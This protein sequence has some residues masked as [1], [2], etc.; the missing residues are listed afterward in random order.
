[1]SPEQIYEQLLSRLRQL[2]RQDRLHN[3]L[4]AFGIFLILAAALGIVLPMLANFAAPS[5][6]MRW[7]LSGFGLLA[8][9]FLMWRFVLQ[10]PLSW[11]L[12][13]NFPSEIDLALRVGR[14]QPEVK[15]RFANALQVFHET[16][17]DS[18]NGAITRQL[19]VVALHEAYQTV[20]PIIFSHIIDRATPKRRLT[21]A[22]LAI[23]IAVAV[24]AVAPNFM[25]Q[26]AA[27]LFA[28]YRTPKALALQFEVQPGDAEIIKGQ[29]LRVVARMNRLGAETAQL[30][31]R[32]TD[33]RV[34]EQAA[35]ARAASGAVS[36][37][38]HT[39]ENIREPL[40]YRIHLDGG[41]SRW[42]NV[43]VIEPPMAR[44]L[45][46]TVKFPTYTGRQ[47]LELDENVGDILALPGS[48]VSVRVTPNKP[49]ENASLVFSYGEVMPLAAAGDDF[50]GEFIVRRQGTYQ[51]ALKDQ[52]G[53]ANADAIQYRLELETDQAPAVQL[54]FPGRDADLDESMRMPL[55]IEGEDDY[56]FSKLQIVYEILEGGAAEGKRSAMAV[57][58][59]N[60]NSRAFRE[61]PIWDLSPLN[62]LP[63]DV[64]RYY[65]EVF[66]NDVISGPKSGRSQTFHLRFPSIYEMY[67]EI[68]S[69]QEE[70]SQDLQGMYEQAKKTKEEIDKLAQ[71]MKKDPHLNWEQKQKLAETAGATQKMQEQVRQLQEKLQEMIDTMERN[72]LLSAQT[73]EKYMELQKLL[74]EMKSPELQKALEE[75][76]KAMQNL[77]PEKLQEAMKNFQ[78]SQ[79]EFLK[80]LERTINLLKQ[81]RAEQQLDEAIKKTEDLLQRQQEVNQEAARNP[82][83]EKREE[84]AEKE[85]GMKQDAQSLEK[86]L[87]DL[88]K[89]MQQL[90]QHGPAEKIESA[91]QM[92]N[93]PDLAG[94]MQ[95]MANR[96]QQG[97]MSQAQQSGQRIAGTLQQM[98][99][100]LLGA[101][102]EMR[103]SNRREVMQALQ[104]SSSDLVQLSKQQEQLLKQSAGMSS[105]SPQLNQAAD[106]QQELI[107]GLQRAGEQLFQL[108]QK[109]FAV[110]PDIARAMGKAMNEMQAARNELEQRN[111]QSA[112]ER[113]GQ[114]MQAL[115]QAV[116]GLRQ[117]MQQGAGMSMAMG[118]EQFMQRMMGL[119]GKQQGI[120]QETQGLGEQG[121]EAMQRQA[122]MARLA[123]EQA[124]VKKSLEQLMQEFGQRG[125]ILG[126]LD[127]TAKDMEEV[128]KALQQ[129]RAD[130]QTI[131]R[132]QQIL[133]RLLDAQRSMRE[134][135]LSKE[136]QAQT[137]KNYRA[138]D[139]GRLPADLGE[140]KSRLYED[141]MRALRENYTRDYKDLIQRYF[142]ALTK[143]QQKSDEKVRR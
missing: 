3:W 139:P 9:L 143:T 52:K 64:V 90:Q 129:N 44:S 31:W 19:A 69:A 17:P 30:E 60:K 46:V 55:V 53:L 95:Q 62:L 73:L 94:E 54:T 65:A 10:S 92:M 138:V 1:M 112:A 105:S 20:E 100:A 81:V 57:S 39:L 5:S 49:I 122:A 4:A 45:R 128:V 47:P 136:R 80:S 58:I 8:F 140:K 82:S 25:A 40:V 83:P 59:S 137:G 22:V 78:F 56:G 85:T 131:E 96:M 41:N 51:I 115:D 72:D 79:E 16:A 29:S 76:Q 110:T 21:A 11:L 86:A 75:M 35:M 99:Q 36:Q 121:M 38:V 109:S 28:P 87:G 2:R 12:R 61:Q 32:Q 104:R 120:N 68:A 101:Q 66:D 27:I 43:N 125:E 7:L 88:N 116:A 70:A 23:I 133:S 42:Y 117:S 118:F 33:G 84:L 91:A 124:A 132:Q 89:L 97:N 135:D 14:S 130:R 93:S 67:Q 37:F 34:T 71:E 18:Q 13:P 74:Q 98:Q 126:R 106:R 77:D 107:S 6:G 15:D 103:D 24:W 108:S 48:T 102:K 134:R 119:S 141:L 114:A 63:E 127:Q 113:Q 123:A 50:R 26:G 111:G 142:D